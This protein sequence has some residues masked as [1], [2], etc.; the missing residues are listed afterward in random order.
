[1]YL[2]TLNGFKFLLLLRETSVKPPIVND[3]ILLT[4][5]PGDCCEE[6][7]NIRILHHKYPWYKP[8]FIFWQN[9]PVFY[10]SDEYSFQ[11]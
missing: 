9:V 11:V 5:S 10:G 4:K 7:F 2:M 6:V 8:S 3:I 1:M